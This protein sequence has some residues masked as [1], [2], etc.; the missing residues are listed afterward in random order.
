[1]YNMYERY[2]QLNEQPFRNTAHPRYLYYSKKHDEALVRL[3]YAVS[4]SKGLMVLTGEIGTGKTYVCK[5]FMKELL[6]K[7]YR[8]AMPAT[9]DL[10][11]TEFL[12]QILCELQMEYRGKSQV[13]AWQDLIEFLE[14]TRKRNS[15]TVLIVDE[16]HL[17]SDRRTLELIRLLL[18]HEIDERYLLTIVLVGQPELWQ[19]IRRIPP[20]NQRLGLSYRLAPLSLEETQEYVRH[21]LEVAGSSNGIFSEEAIQEIH[22]YARGLPREINNICDLSLLIGCGEEANEVSGELVQQAVEDFRGTDFIE[23]RKYS[24]T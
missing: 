2:W 3:L 23:Q 13:E 8:V 11:P 9:P 5:M 6:E 1:M 17:I 7:G 20:L 16:A 18:N 24:A 14:Q 4:E 21:R 19:R 15:E 12:Q 22:T 10:N